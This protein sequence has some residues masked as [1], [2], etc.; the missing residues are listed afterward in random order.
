MGLLPLWDRVG[1][2]PRGGNSG[3]EERGPGCQAICFELQLC[4]LLIVEM[5]TCP[6]TFPSLIFLI[7]K[8]GIT[9]LASVNGAQLVDEGSWVQFPVRPHT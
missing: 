8:M 2:K 6:L 7:Y 3:G 9:T 5:G 4:A 1:M